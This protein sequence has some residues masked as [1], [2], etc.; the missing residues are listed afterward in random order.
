MFDAWFAAYGDIELELEEFN[1]LGNGVTLNVL[2]TRGQLGGSSGGVLEFRFAQVAEWRG[3]L[4]ARIGAYTD[5]DQ[6]RAAAERLAQK[7]R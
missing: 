5:I 1:D 6:A 7:R 2:V 4:I 3:E